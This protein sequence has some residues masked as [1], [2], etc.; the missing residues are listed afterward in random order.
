MA[1]LTI[2]NL[3]D[4]IV[5]ALKGLAQRHRRSMEQEARQIL[6]ERV[7]DRLAVLGEVESSW[8][9]QKSRPR[10]SQVRKWIKD[11]RR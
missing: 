9:K 8:A 10:A 4:E 6:E 3:S 7:G 1:T 5:S 2:R 11:A